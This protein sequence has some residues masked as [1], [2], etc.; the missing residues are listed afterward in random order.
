[1]EKFWYRCFYDYLKC[2]PESTTIVL[3]E[4]P[5]NPPENRE[6]MA[7]IIFETFNFKQLHIGV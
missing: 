3:T 5:L 7:E 6:N 2:D 1:M 4:P